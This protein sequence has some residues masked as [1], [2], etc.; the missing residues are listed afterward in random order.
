MKRY[1]II[2]VAS[3]CALCAMGFSHF[4]E[5]DNHGKHIVTSEMMCQSFGYIIV[6]QDDEGR[7]FLKISNETGEGI[8]VHANVYISGEE[9]PVYGY[10]PAWANTKKKAT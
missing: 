1:I 8:C 9:V 10:V 6:E 3:L 4:K 2:A 7:T 5:S